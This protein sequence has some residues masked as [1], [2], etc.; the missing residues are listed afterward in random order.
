[1]AW[2]CSKLFGCDLRLIITNQIEGVFMSQKSLLVL[3][4]LFASQSVFAQSL[5][6]RITAAHKVAREAEECK[7]IAPF[8]YEIGNKSHAILGDS[9]GFKAPDAYTEMDIASASK[10][11]MGAYTVEKLQGR[12]SANVISLLNFTS[13]YDQFTKCGESLTVAEC[14]ASGTNG[15]QTLENIGKFHYNGGHLQK[16]G[17]VMGIGALDAQMLGQEMT[18]V[19]GF[20]VKYFSPQLAGAV[21]TSAD[22]YAKFLR[23]IMNNELLMGRFLGRHAVCASPEFCPDKAVGSPISKELDYDYS[24][25]HWVE[26]DAKTGDGSFS[27]AGAFGFYPWVDKYKNF[28]GII[29]RKALSPGAGQKSMFCG[30]KI[31]K[32][33]MNPAQKS[34]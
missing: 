2:G 33:F 32:A 15:N 34:F 23:H 19:L 8:Y 14:Q 18:S 27:S 20:N 1:M 13:G 12:L 25:A 11:I 28:Y 21:E 3:S 29:A 16:L 26:N 5:N 7:A 17:V 30:Q 24:L 22:E 4:L 9:I 6:E 31:R 10:W